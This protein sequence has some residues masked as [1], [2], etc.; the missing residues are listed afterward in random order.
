MNLFAAAHLGRPPARAPSPRNAVWVV[1]DEPSAAELAADLCQG[2]GADPSVFRSALPFLRAFREVEPPSAVVLDWRL[3]H[4]LSAA[5]FMAT[6]HRF[7]QLPVIYWTGSEA[8]SL[9]AMIRDD[10]LT[11]IVDKAGGATAFED[12]LHWALAQQPSLRET[13]ASGQ[14]ANR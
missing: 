1:E 10:P 2:C 4:E 7:P 6:R 13:D 8:T 11:I 9:P 5:L 14:E 3:E 12:G